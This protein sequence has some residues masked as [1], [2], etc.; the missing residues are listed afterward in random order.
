ME[1]KPM[2]IQAHRKKNEVYASVR[3][4]EFSCELDDLRVIWMSL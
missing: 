1:S 3:T 2:S 4:S